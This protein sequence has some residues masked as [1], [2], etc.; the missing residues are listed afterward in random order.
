MICWLCKAVKGGGE[1][2]RMARQPESL[3]KKNL[4][5]KE[6]LCWQGLDEPCASKVGKAPDLRREVEGP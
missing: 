4:V 3:K 2:G 1:E 6:R 5:E